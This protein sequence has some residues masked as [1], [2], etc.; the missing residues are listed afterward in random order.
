MALP[1]ALLCCSFVLDPAESQCATDQDC[2]RRGAAFANSTCVQ[3]TCQSLG[4]NNGVDAGEDADAG[5]EDAGSDTGPVDAADQD[6]ID[7]TDPLWCLGN[8]GYVQPDP[9]RP[10]ALTQQFLVQSTQK[11]IPPDG[12]ASIKLCARSDLACATPRAILNTD[13]EGIVHTEVEYGFSG[14][15]EFN[16]PGLQPSIFVVNPVT[17]ADRRQVPLQALNPANAEFLVKAILGSEATLEPT[18]AHTIMAVVDCNSQRFAGISYQAATVDPQNRSRVFYILNP[19]VPSAGG[20]ETNIQGQAGFIN[21]PPGVG[22]I[23]GTYNIQ[24]KRAV[25]IDMPLRAGYF[26]YGLMEPEDFQ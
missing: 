7:K 11:P 15:F 9:L 17:S 5:V 22:T 1:A 24:Q 19:G 8:R 13:E 10:V 25:R 12:G 26:S 6:V 2:A 4:P 18:L 3:N 23:T 21:L 16:S 20:T 14:Y